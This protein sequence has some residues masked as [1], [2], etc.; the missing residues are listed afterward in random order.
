MSSPSRTGGSSWILVQYD[1]H[2]FLV[3]GSKAI[4]LLDIRIGGISEAALM[5]LGGVRV[6]QAG[7]VWEHASMTST[8][9]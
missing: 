3:P 9:T 6:T 2:R 7:Y 1:E 8:T 4:D 5:L